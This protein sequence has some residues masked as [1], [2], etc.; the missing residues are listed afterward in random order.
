[1][2]ILVSEMLHVKVQYKLDESS[3]VSMILSQ[4]STEAKNYMR[5]VLG[6]QGTLTV[7]PLE[8]ILETAHTLFFD[9]DLEH[10]HA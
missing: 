8:Q 7:L 10:I 3:F 2:D 1:M 9:I 4:F 6:T 5:S